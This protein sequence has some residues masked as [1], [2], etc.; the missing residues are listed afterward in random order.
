MSWDGRLRRF[1]CAGYAGALIDRRRAT[2]LLGTMMGGYNVEPLVAL[3]DDDEL[4]ETAAAQLTGLQAQLDSRKAERD[5]T[6]TDLTAVKKL[7]KKVG[8]FFKRSVCR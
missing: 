2:E 7:F 8:K 1:V 3:L 5:L 4:A 6:Q